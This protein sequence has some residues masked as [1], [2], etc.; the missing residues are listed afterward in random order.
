MVYFADNNKQISPCIIA[1]ARY[2]L[3]LKDKEPVN[4]KTCSKEYWERVIHTLYLTN[5]KITA[6]TKKNAINKY[7]QLFM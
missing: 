6:K 5:K 3:K 7:E 4:R 1:K 2:I